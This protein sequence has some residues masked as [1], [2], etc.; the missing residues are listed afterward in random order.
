MDACTFPI[1]NCGQKVRGQAASVHVCRRLCLGGWQALPLGTPRLIFPPRPCP[2]Y[3]QKYWKVDPYSH[4]P[5][6]RPLNDQECRDACA[7]EIWEVS[8]HCFDA[9]GMLA[10]R[11]GQC[12]TALA[13]AVAIPC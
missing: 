7:G 4:Y 2:Q 9:A 8:S 13:A 12:V 5:I 10:L 6:Y 1:W 11:S 3:L